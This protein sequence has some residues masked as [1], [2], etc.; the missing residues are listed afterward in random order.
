MQ[1]EIRFL[2][3]FVAILAIAILSILFP[4]ITW[5]LP[6]F[7]PIGAMV[8]AFWLFMEG[9][10]EVCRGRTEHIIY[11]QG[12]QSVREKDIA[13]IP[14][15]E[16]AT[17]EGGKKQVPLG[18]IIVAQLGGFD[19][20]GFT[21]PGGKSD[22]VLIYPSINHGR[23]ENNYH[24]YGNLT[25]HKYNELPKYIRRTLKL[26]PNRIDPLKTPFY[27]GAT[28]HFIGTA[29]RQNLKIEE[30][31]RELNRDLSEKEKLINKLYEQLIKQKTADDRQ[32]ILGNPIK[33]RD[34]P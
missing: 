28:S 17:E 5:T 31:E 20:W 33:P 21:L 10:T 34:E 18:D 27:Y 1:K 32:Y 23:E 12:H 2:F 26:Y 3:V 19:W 25:K 14:Y 13:K 16:I 15:H 4:G 22:P 9:I 11:N 30:K 7:V 6:A 24:C 8:I 29:T